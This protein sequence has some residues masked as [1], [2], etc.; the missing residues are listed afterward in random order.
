MSTKSYASVETKRSHQS[1]L[2]CIVAIQTTASSVVSVSKLYRG[3]AT[4]RPTTVPLCTYSM[5]HDIILWCHPQGEEPPLITKISFI[6][7]DP[8]TA[9]SNVEPKAHLDHSVLGRR[10]LNMR[11]LGTR[12]TRGRS[13]ARELSSFTASSGS[14]I[15]KGEYGSRTG[16]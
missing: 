6:R 3:S 11:T 7:F 14:R 5:L 10:S 16:A 1:T 15:E 4:V 12:A 13:L 9:N 8:D 2:L